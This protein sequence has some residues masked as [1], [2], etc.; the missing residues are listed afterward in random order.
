MPELYTLQIQLLTLGGIFAI[1]FLDTEAER[2]AFPM[3]TTVKSLPF[4][5][6]AAIAPYPHKMPRKPGLFWRSLIR[7]LSVFGL[8]G[9]D[10]HFETERMELLA[11]NEPCLILMNHSCF[12]DLQIASRILYPRPY[13]IICT[14]DGFVG[15]GG[16]MEWL[17]RS[18]GCVPT[19]K[20]VTDFSLVQDMEYCFKT[21]KTSVLMYPEASYSFDGTCTPLPRKMRV[22]LKKFDVPVVMIETFGAFSRNPLYNELKVRKAVPVTA[23][24]TLLY[25][26]EEL[27]EKTVKE[28]SDGLD[29]AFS[30]DHFRW[31]QEQ[32]LEISEP[33]RADGLHR[34][35]YKCPHCG[36][37]GQM[38]GKGTTLTCHACGKQWELT[39]LG[40]MRALED[41]TEYPHIPDWYAWERQE[42]RRELE[43]GTYRM[44]ADVDIAIMAD[45]SAIYR[46]GEGRLIHDSEGFHLTGC[47]GQL[48]YAQKPQT[49]YGLYADYYW[50]EIADTICIGDNQR[51]YYCFP[52]G[53]PIVAKTRLAAEEL[54]KITKSRK[55]ITP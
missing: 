38:E 30:F 5:E 35:L 2:G 33:F 13:N 8:S 21:L 19:R 9:T 48:E 36:A 55:R 29:A 25:T 12:L 28:L 34:I 32:G 11:K 16:L 46:V 17:M 50:Y 4:A 31:Q 7:C 23:K 22:L 45:F 18:I 15:L 42:V 1:L 39:T 14:C 41:Q 43:N 47:D 54:Y 40:Q 24:A 53:Q 27:H 10:F 37:E 52:K 3:K 20:F 44:E 26:R 49:C 51:L 6:A